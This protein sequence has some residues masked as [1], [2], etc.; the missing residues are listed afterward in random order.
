MKNTNK[1]N[2]LWEKNTKE[3]QNKFL[4][5][6]VVFN[7]FKVSIKL[8]NERNTGRNINSN[9]VGFRN[10][11]DVL[12]NRSD[13]VSVGDNENVFAIKNLRYDLIIPVRNNSS[14]AVRKSFSSGKSGC[15][16]ALVSAVVAGDWEKKEIYSIFQLHKA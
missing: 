10:V 1:L 7:R 16:D 11:V 12:H 4:T 13:W 3:I 6:I 2:I 9:D 15:R 5:K 8:V 14:N